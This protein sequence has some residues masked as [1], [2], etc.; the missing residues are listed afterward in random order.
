M[1]TKVEVYD[2]T[3]LKRKGQVTR[4]ED[5]VARLLAG[6]TGP[7]SPTCFCCALV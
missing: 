2:M 4:G 5:A 6:F 7:G 3:D 1:Q